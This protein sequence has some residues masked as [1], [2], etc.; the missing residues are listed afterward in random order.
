M[1]F[2]NVLLSDVCEVIAGQS[3]PSTTYNIDKIGLPFFQGKADFGEIYP[4]VRMWCSEPKKVSLPDDILISVRAPVGPTNINNLESCIGRGLSAIRC[5][6]K[7]DLRFL[8]NFLRANEN[9]IAAKG[10][11]STFKAITQKDLKSLQ[12][13]LPPLAEQ[14]RIAEILDLADS[15]RQKNKQLIEYHNQLSQSL[16]LDMFGD[17]VTNPKGF[18][19]EKLSDLCGVGSSKRV[20][21][22][23]LM[24]EGVPFYR[25]TEIGEL[26]S[27]G[28][29][30]PKFFI[31]E[32]HYID[33]KN[34][35]GI[36][37]VGDLLMPSI[38]SDGRIFQVKDDKPFYFKDGRVLWVR[39]N[40]NEINSFYL[41]SFLRQIFISNYSAIASGTTFAELKIVSLKKLNILTPPIELQKLYQQRIEKI[42]AQ[43]RQAEESLKK[44]EDLFNSLLQKAFKGEL[45]RGDR[46]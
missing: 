15:V 16:F 32:S 19:T 37:K 22:K 31:T 29:V 27:T 21:V 26:A 3:P 25:G 4:N 6:N 46:V 1:S 17:P 36:P 18:L 13:P 9:K 7:I 14:K 12:I 5:S 39:V 10:T 24:S 40:E 35:G 2:P 43:K 34:H 23:D 44:S 28:Q 30:T 33:L 45:S 20:F 42:E 8:L 41:K 11:G 38:C